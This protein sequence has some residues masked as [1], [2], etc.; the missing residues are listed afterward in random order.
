LNIFDR[1]WH[2]VS[3]IDSKNLSNNSFFDRSCF[4]SNLKGLLCVFLSDELVETFFELDLLEFV[5]DCMSRRSQKWRESMLWTLRWMRLWLLLLLSRRTWCRRRFELH[6]EIAT[7]VHRRADNWECS[8]IFSCSDDF[9]W[10]VREMTS[11]WLKRSESFRWACDSNRDSNSSVSCRSEFDRWDSS[12]SSTCRWL[13]LISENESTS[14]FF[15][16][17][18]I[19]IEIHSSWAAFRIICC[20]IES[21]RRLMMSDE[22]WDFSLWCDFWILRST[23]TSE[24]SADSAKLTTT[25]CSIH[26]TRYANVNNETRTDEFEQSWR[27][28]SETWTSDRRWRFVWWRTCIF[29]SNLSSSRSSS[30]RLKYDCLSENDA[31]CSRMHWFMTLE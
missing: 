3:M 8:W 5:L 21:W 18:W 29:V 25:E 6:R 9:N 31:L 27:F 7:W 28:L 14:T 13:I 12:L 22:C 20:S 4:S 1:V 16:K 2:D 30:S 15:L 11:R 26:C 17:N 23:T 10:I 19:V 24:Q